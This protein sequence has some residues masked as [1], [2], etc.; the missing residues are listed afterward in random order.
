M[1]MDVLSALHG[2]MRRHCGVKHK[3]IHKVH[4]HGVLADALGTM[5]LTMRR[6][7]SD[8]RRRHNFSIGA[9]GRSSSVDRHLKAQGSTYVQ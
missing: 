4:P 8:I 1:L 7:H 5:L 2:T 6:S 3:H 9:C